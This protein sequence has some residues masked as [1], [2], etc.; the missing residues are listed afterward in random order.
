MTAMDRPTPSNDKG[1][2]IWLDL[3]PGCA[4]RVQRVSRRFRHVST[5]FSACSPPRSARSSHILSPMSRISAFLARQKIAFGAIMTK[6]P[7][8]HHS[9]PIVSTN[10]LRL[11]SR[12]CTR[13]LVCFALL[14][15][16]GQRD[17]C[18]LLN[19]PRSQRIFSSHKN[20]RR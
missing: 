16:P 13:Q 2:C 15:T 19:V 8:L 12:S 17:D 20:Q 1:M 4:M 9:R 3:F 14:Y 11:A 5:H 6:L 7:V 18:Y 10:L